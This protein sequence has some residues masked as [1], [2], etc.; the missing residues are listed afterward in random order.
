MKIKTWVLAFAIAFSPLLAISQ[1]VSHDS[2]STLHK[3][4]RQLQLAE[5]TNALQLELLKLENQ[6][7]E[8]TLAV[9]RSKEKAQASANKNAF[10]AENLSKAPQDRKLAK[11]AYKYSRKAQR[12]AFNADRAASRL[13]KL[14][15]D[16]EHKKAKLAE[17]QARLRA[18][19]GN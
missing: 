5:K 1:V 17:S 11:K 7:A 3:Q 2:I 19:A 4:K 18:V 14:R 15:E 16:I 9:Q 13:E 10:I 8:K 6:I 12:E